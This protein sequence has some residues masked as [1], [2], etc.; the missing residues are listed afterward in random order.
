MLRTVPRSRVWLQPPKFDKQKLHKILVPSEICVKNPLTGIEEYQIVN[1]YAEEE[2]IDPRLRA[3]D[4][5][6]DVQIRHDVQ[7]KDCGRYLE[8]STPEEYVET[9]RQLS[10]RIERETIIE[11][12]PDP[13]KET[14]QET[15]TVDNNG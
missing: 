11:Y 3:S 13:V 5:A 2:L 15:K 7:L 14:E 1:T 6:L 4:F 8:P 12:K 9:I 10:N